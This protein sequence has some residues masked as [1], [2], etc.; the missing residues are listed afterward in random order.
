MNIMFG[1]GNGL[2]VCRGASGIVIAPPGSEISVAAQASRHGDNFLPIPVSFPGFWVVLS[3]FI[4]SPVTE[5]R[6]WIAA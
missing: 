2:P 5:R 3:V 6:R 1:A 4:G